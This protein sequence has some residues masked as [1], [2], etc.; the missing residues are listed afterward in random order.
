MWQVDIFLFAYLMCIAFVL[1]GQELEIS[2]GLRMARTDV[3]TQIISGSY[4]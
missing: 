2:C 1:A 3:N 4:T